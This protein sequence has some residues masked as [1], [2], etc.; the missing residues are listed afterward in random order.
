MIVLR[1]LLNAISMSEIGSDCCL[2]KRTIHVI[3]AEPVDR[4]GSYGIKRSEALQGSRRKRQDRN[5]TEKIV[6]VLTEESMKS[7][8]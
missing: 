6:G 3:I 7:L 8:L 1:M 4:C 2:R 5:P